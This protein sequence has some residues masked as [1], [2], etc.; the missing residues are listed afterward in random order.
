MLILGWT[1]IVL[2]LG[3]VGFTYVGY[4]L[5]LAL[6]ARFS[7]R[8][9]MRADIAPSLSVVVA[10]HNGEHALA[11][12]LE[13]TLA[14]DYAGE[15]EILVA[16]DGS[17]DGTNRIAEGFA[18]RGVQLVALD[19]RRGKEAAQAAA[20][21]KARG[22]ILV[23]TDVT[24]ELEPTALAAIVRPFADPTVGC[25]SSEDRVDSDGGEGAYVR[26]EMA[27]RRLENEASSLVGLSGSFFA[28]RREFGSPWPI[29]LA[30]DFRS[31]LEAARRGKRAVS[32]P[33]A[34]ASFKAM[35]DPARE[36][37]RKVRTIR[38]GI[39]VL[40]CYRDVL[41]PRHGRVA[42]SLWGHKVARFTSPF[43]LIIAGL[44]SAALAPLSATAA[45]LFALQAAAYVLG[46]ASLASPWVARFMPA[47]LAGFF[48]L[49]N[50]SM[51]VAWMHHLRG[52]RAVVWE[53]TRR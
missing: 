47:R 5:I 29:D 23:F 42:F 44:A 8:P 51:L 10:V 9:V 19:A 40:S 2:S 4:P 34:R 24:A 37:H 21:A 27:L 46:A 53:P 36:W 35:E 17:T 33:L 32:E 3:W 52:E 13:S 28:V 15:L 16:S 49:V 7:P 18:S 20:I 43:A 11:H 6:L 41:S 39:A 14:L 30:S 38:R 12:K 50:A 45:T 31:A 25:V 22:E 1:L 26:F 48:M